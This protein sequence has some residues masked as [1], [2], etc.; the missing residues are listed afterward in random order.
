MKLLLSLLSYSC[1]KNYIYVSC[2]RWSPEN[3]EMTVQWHYKETKITLLLTSILSYSIW[4]PKIWEMAVHLHWKKMKQ[5]YQPPFIIT[6]PCTISVFF[7][8]TFYQ[9]QSF[10]VLNNL[11]KIQKWL[12]LVIEKRSN[13]HIILLLSLLIL[14]PLLLSL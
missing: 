5:P 12:F 11:L 14:A 4:H 8:I 6:H 13:Y 1:N 2:F 3:G 7:I 9:H 10:C